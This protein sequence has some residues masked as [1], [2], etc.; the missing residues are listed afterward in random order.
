ML[1]VPVVWSNAAVKVYVLPPFTVAGNH[2][3][4]FVMPAAANVFRPRICC[5][6]FCPVAVLVSVKV[7]P[8][9]LPAT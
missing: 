7:K 4:K 6:V 5:T 8:L 1:L 2:S 9:L 3:E